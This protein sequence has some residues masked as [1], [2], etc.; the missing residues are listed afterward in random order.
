MAY[1]KLTPGWRPPSQPPTPPRLNWWPLILSVLALAAAI[2][3]AEF[4]LAGL[5]AEEAARRLNVSVDDAPSRGGLKW[6]GP[7]W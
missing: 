1:G 4:S 6:A 2:G 5:S 7:V 3:V